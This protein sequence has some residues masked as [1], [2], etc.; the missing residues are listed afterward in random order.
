MRRRGDRQIHAMRSEVGIN[1]FL[2]DF[3]AVVTILD[4]LVVR[5]S[6]DVIANGVSSSIAWSGG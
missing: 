6:L 4:G 2:S 3:P 1:N 5:S